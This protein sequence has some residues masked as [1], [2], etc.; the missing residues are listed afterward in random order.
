MFWLRK[1]GEKKMALPHIFP[2]LKGKGHK[3]KYST[4]SEPYSSPLDLRTLL[5]GVLFLTISF[6]DR[7]YAIM[8]YTCTCTVNTL[9]VIFPNLIVIHHQKTWKVRAP[10]GMSRKKGLGGWLWRRKCHYLAFVLYPRHNLIHIP[11]FNRPGVAVAF[12]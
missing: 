11:I 7:L 1:H 8:G 5:Q 9:P 2:Y 4:T 12:L 10:G 6:A 3:L